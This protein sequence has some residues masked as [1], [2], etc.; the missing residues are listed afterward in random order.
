MLEARAAP[1]NQD[2]AAVT[3]AGVVFDQAAQRVE[4]D[5]K[6]I[7]RRD[8][9][10]QAL[11]AREKRFRAFTLVNVRVQNEPAQDATGGVADRKATNVE[12]AVGAIRTANAMFEFVRLAV[13]D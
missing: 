6:R 12:P 5:V 7:P 8:H 2:H 4:D 9:L 11:L 3:V 13:P 10:K 1:I